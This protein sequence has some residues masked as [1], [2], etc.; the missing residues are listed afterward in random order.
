[1]FLRLFNWLVKKKDVPYTFAV[2][3]PGSSFAILGAV[4]GGIILLRR[5][6]FESTGTGMIFVLSLTLLM[7]FVVSRTLIRAGALRVFGTILGERREFSILNDNIISGVIRSDVSTSTLLQVYGS[8]TQLNNHMMRMHL[9]DICVVVPNVAAIEFIASWFITGSFQLTNTLMILL[10]GAIIAALDIICDLPLWE[11]SIYPT[12]KGC[13]TLLAERGVHFEETHF[14]SLRAKSRFFIILMAII[15]LAMWTLAESP[16]LD[17]IVFSIIILSLTVLL[18]DMVFQSFYKAFAEVEESARDLA[19]GNKV[20]FFSGSSD[21]E[22]LDLSKSL[23]ISADEIYSTRKEL[24]QEKLSLQEKIDELE[25]YTS[26]TSHDL[27]QP[28]ATIQAYTQLLKAA[29]KD[30]VKKKNVDVVE[31]QAN[32]MRS[33]LE[34]L[35]NYSRMKKE[36]PYEEVDVKKILE[37]VREHLNPEIEKK[38]AEITFRDLPDKIIAQR[39][40]ITQLFHNLVDNALKY[41]DEKPVVEI[42]CEEREQEYEFYVRDNGIGIEEHFHEKIFKPFWKLGKEP[43][44]GMGLAICKAVV[45]NH[46]GRIWV[47]SEPWRGSTFKFTIPKKNVL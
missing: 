38:E 30:E 18:S 10:V 5:A 37:G 27:Q 7:T 12:R 8:L 35:L 4:L 25:E 33:L 41:S 11:L 28:L 19:K 26:V 2:I 17:L 34:D 31:S 16:N 22:I 13:K 47:E 39:K 3:F 44:T 46:G 32:F 14:M 9:S 24:E 45:E 43:G 1:M 21:R 20:L 36:M 29:E 6:D 15:L 23:N 42:G 40:A